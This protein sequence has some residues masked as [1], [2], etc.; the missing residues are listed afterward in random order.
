MRIFVSHNIFHAHLN[1]M[2][3]TSRTLRQ[4]KRTFMQIY[5]KF[6]ETKALTTAFAKNFAAVTTDMFD[7]WPET[8]E[9]TTRTSTW[10]LASL[11]GFG[12]LV[13]SVCSMWR[14]FIST[15]LTQVYSVWRCCFSPFYTVIAH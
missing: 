7:L 4:Q 3:C 9:P 13:L 6:Y 1:I 12:T 2:V 11:F 15:V 8:S 14:S 10:L 5:S